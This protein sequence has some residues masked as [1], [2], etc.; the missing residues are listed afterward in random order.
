[1]VVITEEAVVPLA[2]MIVVHLEVMIVVPLAEMIVVHL[3]EIIE[4]LQAETIEVLQAE[5]IEVLL[6]EMIN[7][8]VVEMIEAQAQVKVVMIEG[9]M[10]D[11]VDKMTE[12]EAEEAAV[13]MN[14]EDLQVVV[15]PIT[16]VEMVV[17]V[18]LSKL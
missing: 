15:D 8:V 10:T 4:V 9:V 16:T 5:T 18:E 12:I 3:E 2:E 7:E 17:M 14:E 6:A 1:V 11:E 13:E